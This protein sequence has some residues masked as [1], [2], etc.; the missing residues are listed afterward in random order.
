MYLFNHFSCFTILPVRPRD[1]KVGL[2]IKFGSLWHRSLSIPLN[3]GWV[4]P[5]AAFKA[6]VYPCNTLFF[7][8][9]TF[10]IQRSHF[11]KSFFP[12]PLG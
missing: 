1:F 6:R 8:V 4:L 9:N 5:D 7:F 2:L 10:C 12:I 11:P 3:K